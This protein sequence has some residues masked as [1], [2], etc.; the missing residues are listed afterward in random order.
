M[1]EEEIQL[2]EEFGLVNQS[3]DWWK[4]RANRLMG[5]IELLEKKFSEG[6]SNEEDEE[7]M[8]E[9]LKEVKTMIAR[10]ELENEALSQVES[11]T[12]EF[13]KNEYK[14]TDDTR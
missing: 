4:A 6:T 10:G 12:R 1:K 7:L 14:D 2:R 5:Q 9:L 3:T 8:E 13:L 11:K